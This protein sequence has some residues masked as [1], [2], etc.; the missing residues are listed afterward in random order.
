MTITL[1]CEKYLR[2]ILKEFKMKTP[3]LDHIFEDHR[4]IDTISLLEKMDR[5]VH[6][7]HTIFALPERTAQIREKF[8]LICHSDFCLSGGMS[9]RDCCAEDFPWQTVSSIRKWW[10]QTAFF[11]FCKKRGQDGEIEQ[12]QKIMYFNFLVKNMV[13]SEL[14]TSLYMPLPLSW[15]L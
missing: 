10:R 15:D 9:G 8:I 3:F 7:P 5:K 2:Q 14:V 1:W 12:N 4:R 13:R 6:F 11:F